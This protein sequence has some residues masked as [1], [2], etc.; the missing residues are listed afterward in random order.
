MN[1]RLDGKVALVTG[2]AS[3]IGAACAALLAER[4]AK[5][6][7]TDLHPAGAVIAH[8]V[9]DPEQ[10]DAVIAETVA[11]FGRLDILVSNAGTADHGA[12]IDLDLD[13]FRAMARVHV[14]AA[15]IGFQKTVAQL[16]RQ[17]SPATGSLIAVA[18]MAG[19]RPLPGTAAYGTAKA[20]LTHMVR[21]LGVELGRKGDLICVNAVAPAMVRTP[22]S[23][24]MA[25]PGY[26]DDPARAAD[27]PLGGY[28]LPADVAE[29]VAWLASD[30]ARFVTAQALVVD[31][32]WSMAAG[33]FQ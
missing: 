5:V 14:E 7:G 22:M 27:S 13:R 9:T 2:A 25:P 12:I 19:L 1:D 17:G 26:F 6:L 8:D 21:A 31:G 24:R 4:G 30:D 18:S 32:G 3:G 33:A 16:R 28:A 20:A 29:A 15:F 10:W 23:E 11:R